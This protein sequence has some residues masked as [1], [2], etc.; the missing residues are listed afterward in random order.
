MF[1]NNIDL[2]EARPSYLRCKGC[3]FFDAC[4]QR[5][6]VPLVEEIYY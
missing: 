4:D 6:E 3:S 2:L 5:A 1:H